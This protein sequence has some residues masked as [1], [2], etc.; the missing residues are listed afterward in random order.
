MQVGVGG[1]SKPGKRKR[2]HALKVPEWLGSRQFNFRR[3]GIR[4]VRGA[5]SALA[6]IPRLSSGQLGLV[7]WG[8]LSPRCSYSAESPEIPASD[9]AINFFFLWRLRISWDAPAS[10]AAASYPLALV[11]TLASFFSSCFRQGSLLVFIFVF[12]SHSF[13]AA[14]PNNGALSGT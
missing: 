5:L 2:E 10:E 6:V 7:R 13:P 8:F 1:V 4:A 14:S 3:L 12:F 9:R 11:L